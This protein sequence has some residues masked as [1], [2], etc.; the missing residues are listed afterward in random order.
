MVLNLYEVHLLNEYI[1][2]HVIFDK[3]NNKHVLNLKFKRKEKKNC[4]SSNYFIYLIFDIL[5]IYTY[6]IPLNIVLN[7]YLSFVQIH[8]N[9]L[10]LAY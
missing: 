7:K 6:H 5:L 9:V 10:Y 1:S 4:F 3:V 2:I 8:L